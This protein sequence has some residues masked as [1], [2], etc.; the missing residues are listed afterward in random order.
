MFANH[1]GKNRE[2]EAGAAVM[3]MDAPDEP[4]EPIEGTMQVSHEAPQLRQ[5]AFLK[6]FL[7]WLALFVAGYWLVYS[8]VDPRRDFFGRWFPL[9]VT[10]IRQEKLDKFEQYNRQQ[11]VT[12]ILLGSSRSAVLEPAVLDKATGGRFFNSAVFAGQTEDYLAFYR[13][14]REKS[15][16]LQHV[17]VGID[18]LA[19]DSSDGR[20][21]D[22]ESNFAMVSHLEQTQ[23]SLTSA[24]LHRMGLYK[25]TLRTDAAAEMVRSVK[26]LFVKTRDTVEVASDGQV[27]YIERERKIKEGTYDYAGS[28][29]D[30]TAFAIDQYRGIEKLAPERMRYLET[31]IEEVRRDGRKI[32]LWIPPMHPNVMTALRAEPVVE[33]N[34]RRA[35]GYIL[36]LRERLGVRVDDLTDIHGY[37][38]DPDHWYD[39]VH[40]H[41]ADGRKMLAHVAA[42]GL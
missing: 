16:A 25:N 28:I 7:G 18:P 31:L 32:V 17:V 42:K 23:N 14:Y 38:G 6:S 34:Y 29:K 21:A 30:I 37:G 40:Y 35:M 19:M 41:P 39:A 36:G 33:A 2:R 26:G 27:R 1:S 12:G 15:P 5:F 8:I 24:F 4:V 13:I 10:K 22:F 9:V 11:A 3:E 20:T